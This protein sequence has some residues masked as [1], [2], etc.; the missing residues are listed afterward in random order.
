MNYEI[1]VYV[2]T[3][4]HCYAKLIKIHIHLIAF[5]RLVYWE[6]ELIALTRL[7]SSKT[8]APELRM[9]TGHLPYGRQNSNRVS[10]V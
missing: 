6:I 9:I 3:G 4:G 7:T 1:P 10:L 2:A 5:D 8:I